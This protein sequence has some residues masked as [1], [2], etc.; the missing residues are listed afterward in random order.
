MGQ[1]RFG[2]FEPCR[3]SVSNEISKKV[4]CCVCGTLVK[5]YP[6]FR[7]FINVREGIEEPRVTYPTI[8]LKNIRNDWE[9]SQM[10]GLE[11]NFIYTAI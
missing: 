1:V 9:E 8:M 11:H 5:E 6:S 2:P 10:V 4:S 7:N 3:R